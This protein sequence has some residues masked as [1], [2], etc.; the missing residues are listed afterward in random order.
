MV[1]RVGRY[2]QLSV[3]AHGIIAYDATL[4]REVMLVEV[5]AGEPPEA[6]GWEGFAAVYGVEAVDGRAVAVVEHVRGQDAEAWARRVGP[7]LVAAALLRVARGLRSLHAAGGTHGGIGLGVLRVTDDGRVVVTGLAGA[8]DDATRLGDVRDLAQ[9]WVELAGPE[10]AHR[11]AVSRAVPPHTALERLTRDLVAVASPRRTSAWR[12]VVGTTGVVMLAGVAAMRPGA[13]PCGAAAAPIAD[14]WD[15]AHRR[16]VQDVLAEHPLG[17]AVAP[18]VRERLDAYRESWASMAVEACEA[19]AVYGTQPPELLDARMVCL[20]RARG[21]LR[22]VVRGLSTPAEQS[23]PSARHPAVFADDVVAQLPLLSECA[24]GAR[25]RSGWRTDGAGTAT[26]VHAVLAQAAVQRAAG[27]Y[28]AAFASATDAAAAAVAAGHGP[29]IAATHV[30]LGH[31]HSDRGDYGEAEIAFGRGLEVALANGPSASA[32]AAEAASALVMVAGRQ[33][34][35]PQAGAA[36]ATLAQGL[37]RTDEAA[38][39]AVANLHWALAH[40]RQAQGRHQ[41][42]ATELSLTVEAL[43]EAFGPSHAGIVDVRSRWAM[44]LLYLGD[45]DGAHLEASAALTLGLSA[46]GEGHPKVGATR[47]TLGVVLA[48]Q[49]RHAAAER[50]HRAAVTISEQA[51]G[52]AHPSV[53]DARGNLATVLEARGAL[54]EARAELQIVLGLRRAGSSRTEEVRTLWRLGRVSQQQQQLDDAAAEFGA[55]AE[56]ADAAL[57]QGDPLRAATYFGLAE[58][59]EARSE[60]EAAQRHYEACLAQLALAP[61]PQSATVQAVRTRLAGLQSTR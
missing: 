47:S 4:R 22:A 5:A 19:T 43:T 30:L 23:D 58:V 38:A 24:D 36:Y 9:V 14:I 51:L 60:R 33:L 34:D 12:W 15:D 57:R 50:E 26:E 29:S 46:L 6:T 27:R 25:S 48:A 10:A 59:A 13:A 61:V 39:G 52:A 35:K 11:A 17:A 20:N 1:A 37:V 42:A 28:D 8:S 40:L 49:G 54:V 55:A 2:T 32:A 18:R 16:R 53:A 3:Q 7:R 44:V 56:L 31:V 21:H 45:V 41:D